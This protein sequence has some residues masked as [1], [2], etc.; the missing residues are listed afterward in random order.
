MGI[1]LQTTYDLAPAIGM[2]GSLKANVPHVII[3]GK[4]AEASTSIP[5]GKAVCWDLS[6]PV[7]DLDMLLPAAETDKV[8]GI[9]VHSDRYARTWTSA[10]GTVNGELDSTGLRTGTVFDVLRKGVILAK[11][12]LATAVGDRLWVR[13]TATPGLPGDLENADDTTETIDCTKQGQYLS[14]CAANGFA[15]LEV[16]FLNSPA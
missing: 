15:W 6:A 11:C 2:E 1:A 13:C 12:R 14:S 7:T 9:V 16:D 8:T 4:N 10:D 5:F 3:P